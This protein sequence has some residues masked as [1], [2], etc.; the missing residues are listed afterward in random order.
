MTN[1]YFFEPQ[2]ILDYVLALTVIEDHQNIAYY[3]HQ[4]S[5]YT[6]LKVEK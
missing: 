5:I 6:L 2:F 1:T 4:S 3:I